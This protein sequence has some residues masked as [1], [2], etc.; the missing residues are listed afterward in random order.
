MN[1]ADLYRRFNTV[2]SELQTLAFPARALELQR[3][4]LTDAH[5]FL[6]ELADAKR[7]A[8]ASEDEG[9]ANAIL[10]MELAICAVQAQIA[11]CVAL[12]EDDGE[13]AWAH[14]VRSQLYTRNAAAVRAQVDGADA[15]GGLQ[16]LFNMLVA[17][18]KTLFPPQAFMSVGGVASERGC[19]VCAGN[20]DDCGHVKGRA[21]RGQLCHVIVKKLTLE[22]VSIVDEPANKNARVTH[23]TVNG[24]SRN[25]MTWRAESPPSRGAT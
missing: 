15:A 6:D 10:S 18:E 4:A 25:K 24:I 19:S 2:A 21:Y 20:Y 16:N 9:L 13:A 1:D 7:A 14:L 11:T 8:V 5:S 17:W 23:V 12:K 22:E 3:Q